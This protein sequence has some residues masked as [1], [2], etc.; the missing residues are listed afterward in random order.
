MT[1]RP[2]ATSSATDSA[3][4]PRATRPVLVTGAAFLLVVAAFVLALD[5]LQQ[6]A[7]VL[8][9]IFLAL[10]LVLSVDPLRRAAV[11]RGV[12]SW[13]AS[14]VMLIALFGILLV[15]LGGV[16]IALTQLIQLLPEYQDDFAE[17]YAQAQEGLADLGIEVG[18]M[19]EMLGGISPGS[20]VPFLQGVLS[21]LGSVG[22]MVLFI[23]LGMLFLTGDLSNG[24]RRLAVVAS[25]RP[26]L[27]AALRD[28]ADRIRRYWVVCTI[29]SLIEAGLNYTLLLVLDVPLAF[30]WFVLSFV[31]GYIPNVGFLISVVPASLLALLEHGPGVM[32][33]VIVGFVLINF[34]VKTVVMP[35]FTGDVVGLNVTATFLSLLFWTLFVGPLG[36]LLAVPLTLF[37][38]AVLID[39]NERSAWLATFLVS[40]EGLKEVESAES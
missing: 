28:F 20:V 3:T 14:V 10:T 2:A 7:S 30:V 22:T 12:P 33:A 32:V 1:A 21:G 37:A 13:I 9:P 23:A 15:V 36:A 4:S 11:A 34:V 40:D 31:A 18:S 17:Y 35:K 8:A 27:A 6:V 5:G 39:S 16:A 38:K 24:R 19:E 26:Q 25:Y 29:F